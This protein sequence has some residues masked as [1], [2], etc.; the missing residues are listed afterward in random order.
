MG[1]RRA[2][3]NY[4]TACRNAGIHCIRIVDRGVASSGRA[5]GA[6]AAPGAFL[7][8]F[9]GDFDEAAGRTHEFVN[10]VLSTSNT[11][12]R[13]SFPYVSWDSW[14]Y[15]TGIDEQSLRRNAE[16]AVAL[17]VELFVVDLGWARSIGDWYAD[18]QK[19]PSGLAALSEYVHSLGMKF[20]LH[21]A[22]AEA[23]PQSP[24]LQSNPDWAATESNNYFGAA[25]LCLAHQPAKEWVIGQAI[26]MIDEY[27]VDWI[28]QDGENMV[29]TCT[30]SSHTHD[31]ADSNYSNAVNGL[32]AV[33]AAIQ[34]AVPTSSG[35]IAKT[36]AT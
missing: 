9:H 12:D 20:G 33:V 35:R 18:P 23:D 22:L 27:G 1:V 34:K 21:F 4:R 13:K 10:A 30:K 25:S 19:F 17:G 14:S 6:F 26:R 28:L 8:L 15:E 29:K 36:A 32:N 11:P 7:G 24:V 31:P 2:Q 5:G 3:Q 16:M